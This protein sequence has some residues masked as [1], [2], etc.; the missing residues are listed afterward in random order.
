MFSKKKK[1]GAK[2]SKADYVKK[3]I[4]KI[5]KFGYDVY[6]YSENP[7]DAVFTDGINIGYF[8]IVPFGLRF[9]IKYKPGKKTGSGA[10]FNQDPVT[11]D[12]VDEKFLKK[13]LDRKFCR[14]VKGVRWY[15]NFDEWLN[16]EKILKWKKI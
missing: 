13:V 8:S 1:K 16:A 14:W 6:V 4:D 9:S 11:I 3:V 12:C 10:V 5:K 7:I 2:M 15:D